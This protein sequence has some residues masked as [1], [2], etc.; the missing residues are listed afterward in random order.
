[1]RGK[2]AILLQSA[3]ISPKTARVER[4]GRCRVVGAAASDYT[5]Q[6]VSLGETRRKRDVAQPGSAPEWGS[7]GRGFKSRRP[8]FASRAR[9]GG[10]SVRRSFANAAR[11]L[12]AFGQIPQL[13]ANCCE[14]HNPKTEKNDSR[15]FSLCCGIRISFHDDSG[16]CPD[17]SCDGQRRRS[18][19]GD[20]RAPRSRAIQGDPAW[21]STVRRSAPGHFAQ[22][23]GGRLDRSPAQELRLHE[24]RAHHLRFPGTSDSE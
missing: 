12:A 16:S 6:S 11:R 13:V 19:S 10:K 2:R 23:R 15:D 7:G 17:Y 9:R 21:T 18:D 5:P 14:P 4:E 1:M 22:S 3:K 8:D 24:H 20:G